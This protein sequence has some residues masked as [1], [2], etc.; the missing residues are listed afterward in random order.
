MKK[1][2]F[3]LTLLLLV[4]SLSACSKQDAAEQ[5][6]DQAVQDAQ[7]GMENAANAVSQA[8]GNTEHKPAGKAIAS[9]TLKG[10]LPA[11]QGFQANEPEV[12][13]M[14]MNGM[15]WSSAI[16][17]YEN[18]DKALTV[19]IFDWNFNESLSAAFSMYTDG[20]LNIET[21]ESLTRSEKVGGF[22]GWINWEKKSNHG[23]I[24]VI[25]NDRIYVVTE[26]NSGMSIDE[27]RQVANSVDY[28]G[29]AS[30][31]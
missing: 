18:G 27:L 29:I 5:A 25:V 20:N 6:A 3:T 9:A 2:L 15:N 24:G 17:R 21:N 28:K 8:T 30:A 4:A 1:H 31:H 10:Y 22:P 16:Q 13:D 23:Q 11:V 12:V 26:A 7:R 14:S 19:S